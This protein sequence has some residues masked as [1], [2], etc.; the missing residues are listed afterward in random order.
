MGLAQRVNHEWKQERAEG[1]EGTVSLAF[2]KRHLP[3]THLLL[4]PGRP[5]QLLKEIEATPS[6]FTFL[7]E[8]AE[9]ARIYAIRRG[10]L[11]CAIRRAFR[12]DQLRGATLEAR[13]RAPGGIPVRLGLN[14]TELARTT[15][16]AAVLQ[17]AAPDRLLHRGA[18][19]VDISAVD[20]A[21]PVEL[22]DLGVRPGPSAPCR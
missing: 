22:A 19:E 18:N 21:T 13:L 12:D 2:F 14:G 11:G 4:N 20:G 16:G 1:L 15:G 3:V 9:G 7:H 8:T 17:A 6:T 10:G 5:P